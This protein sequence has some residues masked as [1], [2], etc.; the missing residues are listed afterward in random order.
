MLSQ[1][2]SPS[3]FSTGTRPAGECRAICSAVS[4]RF[5]RMTV[6]VKSAPQRFSTSQGRSDQ[7]E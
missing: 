4:G 7:V 6:S 3:T 1:M 2:V 5:R